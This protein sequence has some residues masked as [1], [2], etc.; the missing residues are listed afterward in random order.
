MKKINSGFLKQAVWVLTA[1][2]MLAVNGGIAAS[3]VVKA[4]SYKIV[5]YLPLWK[6]WQAEDIEVDKLTHINL[7][8]AGI[9]NGVIVDS[10]KPDL[11]KAFRKLKHQNPLVKILI[12]IGGWGADGFSDTSLTPESRTVFAESV[13]NYLHKYKLDGVDIDWEFPVAGGGGTKGRPEDKENFTL[14]M[15]VLRDKLNEAGVKD[16]KQYLLSFAASVSLFYINSVELYQL[17][18]LV[19]YINLMTYDF[20]GAWENITGFHTNLYTVPGDPTSLSADFGLKRYLQA[21]VPPEKIML[22]TAFYGRGWNGVVNL[23]NGRFQPVSGES[24]SYSY[25][26]LAANYV[27]RNGFL[28]YWDDQ[29]KAPYLWN[30][31]TFIAYEDEESLGYRTIF[32]RAN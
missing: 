26:D 14:L 16:K 7:A 29:A 23:N 20:H 5:A 1:L 15:Q 27:N 32:I 6:T 24:K 8:F 31:D 13:A 18:P 3:A 19:D 21:G 17:A 12:S 25:Q 11:V 28:R 9:R 10:L 2:A 22:G 30:G 4:P